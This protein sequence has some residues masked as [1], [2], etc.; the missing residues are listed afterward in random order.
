MKILC[1][2]HKYFSNIYCVLSEMFKS[3]IFKTKYY[4]L[5][6]YFL[7]EMIEP[8]DSITGP[9]CFKENQV[10]FTVNKMKPKTLVLSCDTQGT[11]AAE[12]EMV[13]ISADMMTWF[14]LLWCQA[15]WWLKLDPI[16]IF[17]NSR[18]ELGN[19]LNMLC[20]IFY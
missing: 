9:A 12:W 6:E 10:S 3:E 17:D 5:N 19:W 4:F 1:F 11:R 2:L 18:M 14:D 13:L 7:S 20:W 16:M 15:L 8:V